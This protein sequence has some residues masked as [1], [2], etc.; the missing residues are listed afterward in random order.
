MFITFEGLDYS[1]KSTQAALLVERL[2]KVAQ[3]RAIRFIREPGGTPVSEKI[4]EILLDREHH[5]IS[6]VAEMLLFSASRN[7]LVTEVIIPA[8]MNNEIVVCDRYDDSTTAYQGYGRGLD[9]QSISQMNRLAT[10]GV[11][12]DLTILLDIPLEEIAR[13][14]TGSTDRMED[15][16]QQFHKRVRDGYLAIARNEPGRVA[17]INGVGTTGQISDAIWERVEKLM[18]ETGALSGTKQSKEREL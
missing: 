17:V 5:E 11:R 12:P 9:L 16:G 3:G 6:E 7:Q 2:E 18:S 4:R 13:R 10:A 15:A 1:G 8:L 14:N